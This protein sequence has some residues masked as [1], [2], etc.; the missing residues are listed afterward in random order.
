[1]TDQRSPSE[2]LLLQAVRLA[3]VADR[4]A[5]A[6]RTF[7]ADHEVDRVLT[8]AHRDG[9][10]EQFAFGETSGW[11]LTEKG[12][13]RLATLLRQEASERKAI[14]ALD[15]TL[16]DFDPLNERLVGLVS[17]WQ[18]QST[19]STTTG[20]TTTGSSTTGFAAADAA[21]VD[22]LLTSLAAA[23]RDLRETL[24]GLIRLLPRFGRYPAQYATALDRAQHEGLQWITGV[25]LLSCHV[26][27]A[28]LH[29]DLLSSLGRDRLDDRHNG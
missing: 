17:R 16:E 25:G 19:A 11:I 14:T 20:A 4:E 7:L 12:A 28:E 9:A 5:I 3:G 27:W 2:L 1:M 15:R 22:E 8:A 26:V 10:L 6:D 18:L 23:G 13:V 21:R 29:Q 24:E